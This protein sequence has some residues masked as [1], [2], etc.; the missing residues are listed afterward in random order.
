LCQKNPLVMSHHTLRSVLML[1]SFVRVHVC[2]CVWKHPFRFYYYSF[3]QI[4]S[5][6]A[7]T[8]AQSVSRWVQEFIL[9]QNVRLGSWAHPASYAMDTGVKH[10][11]REVYHS[12]PPSAEVMNEWSCISNSSVCHHT[13]DWDFFVIFYKCATFRDSHVVIR[14]LSS[15]KLPS[16]KFLAA[17]TSPV[18]TFSRHPT[19]LPSPLSLI[20]RPTLLHLS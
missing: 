3:V 10:L 12:S 7:A 14:L 2:V 18:H 20:A 17:A 11:G 15:V 1:Y 16:F 13:V 8:K 19:L 6:V 9:L 5:L 4:S